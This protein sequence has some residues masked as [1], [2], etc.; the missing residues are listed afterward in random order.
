MISQSALV[1]IS[2]DKELTGETIRVFIYLCS[3]LDFQKYVQVRQKE[4]AEYLGL[5]ATN[6][7]RAISM[8][9][10]KGI[11]I[12]GPKVSRSSSF[13]LNQRYGEKEILNRERHLELVKR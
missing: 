9:G 12:K 1:K 7:S 5:R 4:I 8:L 3:R 6:V 10:R 11:I 2:K 13:R